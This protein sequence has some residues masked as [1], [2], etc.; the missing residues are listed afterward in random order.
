[1]WW[2]NDAQKFQELIIHSQEENVTA[3]GISRGRPSPNVLSCVFAAQANTE[4]AVFLQEVA[5]VC[6][7]PLLTKRHVESVD[8][9]QIIPLYSADRKRLPCK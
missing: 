6:E 9:R 2:Q 3:S 8:V 4:Y 5:Y 1:V 7:S